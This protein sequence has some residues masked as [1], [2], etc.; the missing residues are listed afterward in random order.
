MCDKTSQ[1]NQEPDVLSVS[2]VSSHGRRG[3]ADACGHH[4]RRCQVP[5]TTWPLVQH[6][7]GNAFVGLPLFFPTAA[8]LLGHSGIILQL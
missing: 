1:A 3:P 2:K 8:T 4:T 7:K 5:S 6:G